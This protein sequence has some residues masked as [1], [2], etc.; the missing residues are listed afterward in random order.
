MGPM[1]VLDQSKALILAP[2]SPPPEN[3]S[4]RAAMW[5]RSREASI[6]VRAF[7]FCLRMVEKIVF[8]M[9]VRQK[10]EMQGML[11]QRYRKADFGTRPGKIGMSG[12][13]GSGFCRPSWVY[14]YGAGRIFILRNF[15][16]QQRINELPCTHLRYGYRNTRWATLLSRFK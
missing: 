4:S 12:V 2:I 13:L 1:G 10:L 16:M 11:C 14:G 15:L 3:T 7:D 8:A 5:G 6:R 9:C